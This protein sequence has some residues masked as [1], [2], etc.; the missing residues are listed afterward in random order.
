MDV[1]CTAHQATTFSP[2]EVIE[3]TLENATL[4]H[5]PLLIVVGASAAITSRT[6]SR[7]KG[8]PPQNRP[9]CTLTL[10]LTQAIPFPN[11]AF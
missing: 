2:L 11:I 1:V 7:E 10:T 8:V 6:Y 4:Y 9:V 3:T 5:R